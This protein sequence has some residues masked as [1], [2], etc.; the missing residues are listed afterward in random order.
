MPLEGIPKT[1]VSNVIMCK[2]VSQLDLLIDRKF[3][4]RNIKRTPWTF[5]PRAKGA[6]S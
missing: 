1:V 3:P 2:R 4:R 6:D 5:I